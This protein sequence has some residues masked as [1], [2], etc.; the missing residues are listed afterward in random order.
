MSSETRQERKKRNKREYAEV[1]LS[2]VSQIQEKEQESNFK[3]TE[4]VPGSDDEKFWDDFFS[5]IEMGETLQGFA[6]EH[7]MTNQSLRRRLRSGDLHERF[8]E[9]HQGRAVY[10]AQSIEGMIDRL[11]SGD[12]ESDVARVSIDARKWLATKY[13]PRMFGERQE[14]NLKTTDMTKVYVE[15]LKM[16][17]SSHDQRMKTIEVKSEVK[18]IAKEEDE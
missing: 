18:M 14:V 12:V 2:S 9:A 15:Q 3:G 7:N 8:I 11:E 13:Y 5:R 17:M 1:K 6:I 4:V 16:I 10:H